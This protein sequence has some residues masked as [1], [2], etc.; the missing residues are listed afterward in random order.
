M[1]CYDSGKEKGYNEGFKD[2]E[3]GL[4]ASLIDRGV[5][6][7]ARVPLPAGEYKFLKIFKG[8]E[9][10]SQ[11]LLQNIESNGLLKVLYY[12]DCPLNRLQEGQI[13]TIN[14]AGEFLIEVT[15]TIIEN[16]KAFTKV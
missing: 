13:F 8:S 3:N 5:I 9:P 16:G 11:G 10:F 14:A 1:I 15:G 6:A 2:G 12:E 4:I 7:H